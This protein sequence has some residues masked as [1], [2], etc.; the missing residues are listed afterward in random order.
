MAIDAPTKTTDF[1]GFLPPEISEPIFEEAAR[2]SV[3]M[4]MSR[5]VPLPINGKAIP[6]TT[7]KP[8]A[9]WVSEGGQ[10]PDTQGEMDLLPMETKEVAASAVLYAELVRGIPG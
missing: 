10:K 5:R 2:Q 1:E 6:I 8:T 3:V 9:N 7:G 4:S